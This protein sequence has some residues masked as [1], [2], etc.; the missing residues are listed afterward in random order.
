MK[1]KRE[2]TLFYASSSKAILEKLS[3]VESLFAIVASFA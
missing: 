2:T 1:L 3:D